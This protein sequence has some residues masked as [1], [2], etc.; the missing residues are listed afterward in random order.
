MSKE[1]SDAA[2]DIEAWRQAIPDMASSVTKLETALKGVTAFARC[3]AIFGVAGA[4]LSVVTSVLDLI[5]V[6]EDQQAK[7]MGMIQDLSDAVEQLRKQMNARFDDLHSQADLNAAKIVLAPHIEVISTAAILMRKLHAEGVYRRGEAIGDTPSHTPQQANL[8]MI[9][10]ANL[11]RELGR[12]QVFNAA[13]AITRICLSKEP[14]LEANILDALIENTW[15]DVG[16]LMHVGSLLA[17]YVATAALIDNLLCQLEHDAANPDSKSPAVQGQQPAGLGTDGDTGGQSGTQILDRI[18]G[19]QA[20]YGLFSQ[21]IAEHL[22]DVC[23]YNSRPDILNKHL[24]DRVE[25]VLS[26]MTWPSEPNRDLMFQTLANNIL[27]ELNDHHSWCSFCVIVYGT[28]CDS[29]HQSIA[30]NGSRI[31]YAEY[32]PR[33]FGSSDHSAQIL[34]SWM[35]NFEGNLP[36]NVRDDCLAWGGTVLH[37]VIPTPKNE[38][39]GWAAAEMAYLRKSSPQLNEGGYAFYLDSV[40]FFRTVTGAFDQ[41]YSERPYDYFV[42]AANVDRLAFAVSHPFKLNEGG[43]LSEDGKALCMPL[44]SGKSYEGRKAIIFIQPTPVDS[45]SS[46]PAT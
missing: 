36:S 10:A 42:F 3:A 1:I 40:G 31:G 30:I 16:A 38:T 29:A 18:Q 9:E 46:Q 44:V 26:R 24:N 41:V 11:L 19:I 15:G 20:T 35:P 32:H 22:E 7:L 5:G 45:E 2:D 4:A 27:K 25:Y 34:V 39:Q 17:G 28:D 8:I 14:N 37:R 23:R 13:S 6:T 12:W 33:H 21:Q 43:I